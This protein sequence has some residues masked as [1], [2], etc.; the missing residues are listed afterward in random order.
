MPMFISLP[1]FTQASCPD[2]LKPF[3]KFCLGHPG[4]GNVGNHMGKLFQFTGFG[5]WDSLLE[6]TPVGRGFSLGQGD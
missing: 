1:D 6:M 4:L 3:F 5:T 2:L